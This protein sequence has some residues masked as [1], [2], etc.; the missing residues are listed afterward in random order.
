VLSMELVLYAPE[1]LLRLVTHG[2]G[3]WQRALA[4]YP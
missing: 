2:N 1:R 3:I 4:S